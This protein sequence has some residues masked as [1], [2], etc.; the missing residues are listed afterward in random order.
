MNPIVMS[1]SLFVAT[2][3]RLSRY[4]WRAENHHLVVQF[5]Q[6]TRKPSHDHLIV[7]I[8]DQLMRFF[9]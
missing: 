4:V 5:L 9:I 1:D 2:Q 8:E 3:R 6:L 7:A